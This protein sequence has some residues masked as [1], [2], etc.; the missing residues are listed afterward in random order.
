MN[1]QKATLGGG[2]F[3]C[4]EAIFQ[5]VKGVTQV[6]SGYCG[7]AIPNPTY[8]QVC[9]GSTG[10]AEVI[11]IIFDTTKI[12]YDDILRIFFHLH[13]PTTLNRQGGDVGSQYR[14]VIFHHDEEQ[15]NIAEKIKKE[16]NQTGL[17][18]NSI[19]TQ[20][21]PCPTFY[22][23]EDYHQNYF[24]TNSSQPYCQVVIIP[25]LQKFMDGFKDMV[26]HAKKK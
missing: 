5:Q 3:W 16:I 20:I 11:Q 8:H 7:G 12:S 2:C 19:V 26:P 23:A 14:S 22:K 1:L 6:V 10:H 4:L 18:K 15:K 24:Q 17:W 9:S 21:E 25:K 13:D